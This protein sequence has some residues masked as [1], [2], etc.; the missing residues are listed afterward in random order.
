MTSCGNS[1]LLLRIFSSMEALMLSRCLSR[2]PSRVLLR[3]LG[4]AWSMVVKCQRYFQYFFHFD[5]MVRIN[6]WRVDY[7]FV[8][9]LTSKESKSMRTIHRMCFMADYFRNIKKTKLIQ[10]G[11]SWSNKIPEVFPHLDMFL[12]GFIPPATY[13]F[14]KGCVC[15][16]ICH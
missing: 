4:A 3:L 11:A 12:S 1:M 5:L 8:H 13:W 6:G 2:E 10:S 9:I 7:H 14:V 16:L 15:L